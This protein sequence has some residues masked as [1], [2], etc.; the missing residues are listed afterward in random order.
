MK[1]LFIVDGNSIMN[2]A[3]FGVR[4]LETQS[5]IYTNAVY[6]TATMLKRQ[7][8]QIDP[9]YF[10]VAF[11]L[12]A[13]TFRHKMYDLYKSNRHGMPDELRAQEP[14][15][16]E[17]VKKMGAH[18]IEIEGYEADDILGTM[19]RLAEGDG[20]QTYVFTGDRDSLQLISDNTSVL[21]ATN[22]EAV[23]Y[24]T[25]AFKEKYGVLPS[26]FVDVKALMGDSSDCIPGV[27]GIGE[28]T[29]LSLI[30]EY[31]SLDGLYADFESKKFTPS[32][33]AKLADGKDS[34]YLSQ[35]LARIE[36]EA[37]L[38]VTLSDVEYH[39]FDKAGLRALFEK[40]EF[41]ALIKKWELDTD[42]QAEPKQ[43]AFKDAPIDAL[44][45]ENVAAFF[46]FSDVKCYFSDGECVASCPMPDAADY[47]KKAGHLSV[48]DKK[49][50]CHALAERGFDTH[51]RADDV[52]I[53]GYV[54]SVSENDYSLEKLISR[55]FVE[56]AKTP[57]E[58]AHFIRL[59]YDNY[60]SRMNDAE[61]KLYLDI[62]LPL[63]DVLFRME[64]DGF[65]VDIGELKK[66]SEK[67]GAMQ[68]EY[69][70]RIFM[71]AGEQFNI[72]SPK[73]LGAILF[74]KLGLP[75][76]KK[77]KSGYSTSADVLERLRPY[78]E[79]ID[80]ILEYRQVGK[81][82]STYA[83]GL[84]RAAD[85]NGRV[86]TSFRQ[87]LTATGRLSSTEPNL[88]N[89]PIKTELGRE[90]RRFFIA[91]DGYTLIDADYSQIELRLLAAISGDENMIDAFNSGYD[92]H[93]ATAMRV[94]GVDADGVTVALRKRAKAINFGIV[95]GIGDFSLSGDLHVSRKEAA[96][97]IKSYFETYPDV[98]A[99]LD[100]VVKKAH[101]NKYVETLF[102]RRRYIPELSSTRK[103]E[104]AFGERVA[105]NSPIQGTAADIIKLAMVNTS[106]K[107]DE[108]G[109][110][111]RLILQVH[112]ELIIE[113]SE[114]CADKVRELLKTEMEN[115]VSLPVPLTVSI[116]EG[117]TWFDAK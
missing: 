74:E 12:H 3:F 17:L 42:D 41:F 71:L 116:A 67:L 20:V 43:A 86:H 39:G 78:S 94:F 38:G 25:A 96:E 98:K 113:A 15:I 111:A 31:G 75:S 82:K 16:H 22:A 4:L 109:L 114:S 105:M 92:I 33:T 54:L 56:E 18:V 26:Q 95:Y 85:E 91:R 103:L 64:R 62:E 36:R 23:L 27:R 102:G 63:C 47:I 84:T 81:L 106:K 19:S 9:D 1:K 2:R 107:L 87:A 14:Y 99:Y 57:A 53:M 76:G 46:D 117:K 49:S 70:Q 61:K 21:L 35:T 77:T 59:L 69:E 45:F 32:V 83:D 10:A 8:D 48:Y 58:K 80:D 7:L 72:N 34:A 65:L 6:G 115:A 108:P 5:G 30:A 11:D 52:M 40:L 97:Y 110:D 29:A 68:K 100:G 60:S 66:F 104:Q 51:F 24:D 93:T 28:K 112:D 101:E 89:I 55:A 90:F 79:I 44:N 88:Q 37:P 73:Q 13:P 50:I